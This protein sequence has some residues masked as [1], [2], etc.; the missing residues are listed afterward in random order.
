MKIVHG[1]IGNQPITQNY[2]VANTWN[3]VFNKNVRV[4]AFTATWNGSSPAYI[5]VFDTSGHDGG[6]AIDGTWVPRYSIPLTQY[7]T[8]VLAHSQ[9]AKGFYAQI[10]TT[11]ST[12]GSSG[13]LAAAANVKMTLEYDIWPCSNP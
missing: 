7:E 12:G 3:P 8:F 13:T 4:W 10:V 6:A 1:H 9:F 5:E 11:P 2:G